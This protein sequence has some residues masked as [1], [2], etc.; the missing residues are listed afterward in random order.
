METL[1]KP[2]ENKV[3]IV[4]GAGSGIGEAIAR[5]LVERGAKLLILERDAQSGEAVRNDLSNLS[6]AALVVGDAGDPDVCDQTIQAALARWGRLDILVN[7]AGGGRLVPTEALSTA[8]WR[9][10]QASNMDTAFFM[11]RAALKPMLAQGAGSIVNIASVHGHVGFA[12]HVAYGAAKGAVLNMT[13]AMAVEF[14]ARGIRV[15]SISPGVIRTPAFDRAA[16][17]GPAQMFVD[18]HPMRRLGSPLD[19]AL[20]VSFIAS[21]EAAFITGANLMVDGGLTAQ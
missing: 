20:A 6:E 7:N 16:G 4:T 12:N 21:D 9:E 10:M 18:L 3:V 8:D 19:V 11:S 15:N 2:F 17:D 14:A 5:L 13:R 1:L